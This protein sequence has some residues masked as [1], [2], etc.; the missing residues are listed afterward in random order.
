MQPSQPAPGAP[1]GI[2]YNACGD[3]FVG[4]DII[5]GAFWRVS[6]WDSDHV[7]RIGFGTVAYEQPVFCV[8]I[9]YD[10]VAQSW[11]VQPPSSGFDRGATVQLD[12]ELFNGDG[13]RIDF[14]NQSNT[15]DDT[16]GLAFLETT[17]L[18]KASGGGLTPEE[19]SWL[20]DVQSAV[21]R[22][23]NDASGAARSTPVG[24]A[25][26][27]PD[28]AFF[29]NPDA[30]FALT[31]R[32]ELAPPESGGAISAY[33]LFLQATTVPPGFGKRDG[34][35]VEWNERLAQF[36]AVHQIKASTQEYVDE[37]YELHLDNTIWLWRTPFPNHVLYDVTAGCVVTAQWVRFSL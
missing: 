2:G 11:N 34:V 29:N 27:H 18:N 33:G 25:L 21:Q 14:A 16:G 28:S 37:V 35:V 30:P 6:L 17:S 36:A 22:V 23:F 19:H 5:P 31:G 7:N 13:T 4:V 20:D 12:Y 3:S 15:Y 32:G 24:S 26:S 9:G 10:G 8:I 1:V